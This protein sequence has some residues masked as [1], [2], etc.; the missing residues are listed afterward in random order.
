MSI[1][2][3]SIHYVLPAYEG[4]ALGSV[5]HRDR[6]EIPR[7]QME[8][9]TCLRAWEEAK[10]K[11]DTARSQKE[12]DILSLLVTRT[13]TAYKAV[14]SEIEEYMKRGYKAF[15]PE[16]VAPLEFSVRTRHHGGFPGE[17][18][19]HIILHQQNANSS[20]NAQ[21]TLFRFIT[22]LCSEN[23]S[24]SSLLSSDS[25][26]ALAD[27]ISEMVQKESKVVVLGSLISLTRVRTIEPIG[28]RKGGIFSASMSTTPQ[29]YFVVSEAVLGGAFLGFGSYCE[30]AGEEAGSSAA[31]GAASVSARLATQITRFSFISKGA[32]P[33]LSHR[34]EEANLW[35]AYCNWKESLQTDEHSGYPLALRVC[36]LAH[37]FIENGRLV[38]SPQLEPRE[39]VAGDSGVSA[40]TV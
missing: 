30:V 15:Q 7:L 16:E 3:S 32:I 28:I 4:F 24:T 13:G 17:N 35:A 29:N 25:V 19:S 39:L 21:A 36:S 6:I 10:A 27:R 18:M 31:A 14:C 8:S 5:V 12:G 9:A 1:T 38:P 2:S 22:Q 34:F 20:K 23:H 26:A 11:L 40:A 37:I 33:K